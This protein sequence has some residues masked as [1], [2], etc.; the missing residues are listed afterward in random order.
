[1]LLCAVLLGGALGAYQYFFTDTVYSSTVEF[2]VRNNNVSSN[3]LSTNLDAA[4]ALSN[5]YIKILTSD[6]VLSDLS[7]K[8]EEL[9]CP[10]E[11]WEISGMISAT[12]ASGSSFFYVSAL[13]TN[14]K[15]ATVLGKALSAVAPA[16][17][18]EVAKEGFLTTEYIATQC[19]EVI[20]RMGNNEELKW[21]INEPL[22]Y[23]ALLDKAM[24]EAE[25]TGVSSL[26]MKEVINSLTNNETLHWKIESVN[27]D[28]P[29][30]KDK[31]IAKVKNYL[32]DNTN[33][34]KET[35]HCFVVT[36]EPPATAVGSKVDVPK[37]IGIGALAGMVI[38]YIIV[39]L[40]SL[41]ETSITTEE[42]LRNLVNRPVI[43]AIPTWDT[44][45][46]AKSY[47]K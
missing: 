18:T 22:N 2:Y 24:T 26:Q 20:I 31:F 11:P 29:D 42:D 44:A 46:N 45:K 4:E 5:D 23:D 7:A 17:V 34:L 3:T 12:S 47:K 27:L 21:N 40:K 28:D 35:N 1:M 16:S 9:G 30:E 15:K 19:T 13:S 38:V 33:L 10:M 32:D 36:K 6:K 25:I 41:F 37:Y 39:F 43:G 14:Q 8:C